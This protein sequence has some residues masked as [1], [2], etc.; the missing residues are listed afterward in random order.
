[1]RMHYLARARRGREL[2]IDRECRKLEL[3]K[4]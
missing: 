4:R 1:M 2:V 3:S